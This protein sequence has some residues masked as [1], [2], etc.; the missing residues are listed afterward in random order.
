MKLYLY[1]VAFS[2]GYLNSP[3]HP[4]FFGGYQKLR[5]L[6]PNYQPIVEAFFLAL[7]VENFALGADHLAQTSSFL[8]NRMPGW[9]LF[10][11]VLQC[12]QLSCRWR[13]TDLLNL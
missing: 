1:D 5:T 11:A 7:I 6:S 9:Q 13:S 2:L 10:T 8:Y 3:L 12:E 4:H